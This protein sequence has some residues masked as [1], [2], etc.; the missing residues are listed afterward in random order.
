M[1]LDMFHVNRILV[2][3]LTFVLVLIRCGCLVL[4]APFFSSESFPSLFRLFLAAGLALLLIPFAAETAA[5]PERMDVLELALLAGQELVVG[6]SIA[7][8]G[9]IVFYGLQMAGEIAGQQI[10]FSMANVVDPVSNI[11]VPILGYL[12]MNVAMALFIAAKLHLVL[13]YIMA[14]SYY[15]V[16]IGALLPEVNH[17]NP[18]L[19]MALVQARDLLILGVKF[20]VPIMLIMLLNNIV[21]GFVAKT[22]PQMNMMS[23]GMPLRMV[24]GVSAMVFVYPVMCAAIIP[25]DWEFN[26]QDMPEGPFGDMLVE[27]S[28][29][30]E[31]MGARWAGQ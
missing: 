13:I 14:K 20:A 27:L 4:F 31:M 28:T 5:T 7:F 21:E 17:N 2:A 12:N 30:V 26:L 9:S 29:M 23:L 15:Y 22:M 19:S 6:M 8:L 1:S 11:E 25:G 10:G 18:A 24:I 16:G 3:F